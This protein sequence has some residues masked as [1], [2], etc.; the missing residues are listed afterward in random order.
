[1]SPELRD[2]FL[3]SRFDS[4]IVIV[5]LEE[6]FVLPKDGEEKMA[7]AGDALEPFSFYF[8]LI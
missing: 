1:M 7:K 5:L 3:S 4:L 2:F 6:F 8:I